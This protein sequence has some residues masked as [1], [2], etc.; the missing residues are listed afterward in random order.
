MTQ[1]HVHCPA[2]PINGGRFKVLDFL[3]A[4]F[5]RAGVAGGAVA[6]TFP[7]TSIC[8]SVHVDSRVDVVLGAVMGVVHYSPD[9]KLRCCSVSSVVTTQLT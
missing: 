2:M 4:S 8:Y 7:R 6:N 5:S 9:R 3:V 1:A